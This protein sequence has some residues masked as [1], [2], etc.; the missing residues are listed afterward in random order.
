MTSAILAEEYSWDLLMVQVHAPDSLNH[1]ALGDL[2]EDTPIY[3]PSRAEVAWQQFRQEYQILDAF[4]G[5]VIRDCADD[6]TL[7]VCVSDHGCLPARKAVWMGDAFMRAGLTVYIEDDTTQ[8]LVVDW[9]QTKAL[10]ATFP[11]GHGVW[12]NLKGRDPDGIV[13]PGSE[14]EAVRTEAINALL[15]VVDP[16]TGQRPIALALRRED[17]PLVGLGGERVPDCVFYFA[18]GYCD[19]YDM[20]GGGPLDPELVSE[21]PF[22]ETNKDWYIRGMHHCYLPTATYGGFSNSGILVMKGPGIKRGYRRT[23][24]AWTF[25]VAPTIAHLLDMPFPAQT[26]GGVIADVLSR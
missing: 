1:N 25:D 16:E 6:K 13:E 24:S 15:S 26:D 23:R 7:V 22:P 2:L 14:Y 10:L 17:A 20:F 3:E 5:D 21:G 19:R 9:D 18:P 12:V 11:W 8:K 4:V